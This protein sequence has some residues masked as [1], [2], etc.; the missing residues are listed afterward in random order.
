MEEKVTVNFRNSVK[1][2]TFEITFHENGSVDVVEK[3][4][5]EPADILKSSLFIFAIMMLAVIGVSF[6]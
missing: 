3:I 2:Q 6:L 5:G 4:C 1:S